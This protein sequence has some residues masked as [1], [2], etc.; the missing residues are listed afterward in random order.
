MI[1]LT[2]VTQSV[3]RRPALQLA[4]ALTALP[5]ALTACGGDATESGTDP[6]GTT[7]SELTTVTFALGYLPVAGDNGFA[8][9]MR[10]GLFEEQGIKI[11][12]VPFNGT[13]TETLVASGQVDLGFGG[14]IQA[15]LTAF[16]TDVPIT[17]IFAAGQ[18]DTTFIGALTSSGI[19]E[20]ADFVGKIYGGYGSPAEE[21]VLNTM[22]ENDGGT[23]E[24]KQVALEVGAT[25]ALKADQVDLAVMYTD[26]AYDFDKAGVEYN[27]IYPQEFGVPDQEQFNVVA[28]N[29][30]LD[31]HPDLAKGL[32][33]ALQEGYQVAIDDPAAANAAL[34]AEFPELNANADQVAFVNEFNAKEL[35][36]N[37]DGLLVGTQDLD[38][39]QE[40]ADWMAEHGLLAD[41][42]GDSLSTFDPT[43]FVTNEYLPE[44]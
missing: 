1:R 25:E 42:D 14:G 34:L 19:T 28:G 8:Y 22:I 26:Y 20:P 12:I 23:G 6:T 13:A 15:G 39:W 36:P 24:V 18:R 43:P 31:E 40:N 21:A 4:A 2:P 17:S 38:M 29:D 11:K 16:A 37:P 33:A 30:W 9:A 7:A 35:W 10:E 32:V 5:L 41:V 3:S 27:R 44:S